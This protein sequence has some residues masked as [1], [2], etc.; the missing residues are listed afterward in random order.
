MPRHDSSDKSDMRSLISIIIIELVPY[1]SNLCMKWLKQIKTLSKKKRESQLLPQRITGPY[2]CWCLSWTQVVHYSVV[3]FLFFSFQQMA[4]QRHWCNF[5]SRG[6]LLDQ[7]TDR[8]RA[9]RLQREKTGWAVDYRKTLPRS[10]KD[11][12]QNPQIKAIQACLWEEFPLFSFPPTISAPWPCSPLRIHSVLLLSRLPFVKYRWW[13]KRHYTTITW[14][15]HHPPRT[16]T[17]STTRRKTKWTIKD[18]IS[19][20]FFD[21]P[22]FSE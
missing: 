8:K 21:M 16:K 2:D 19:R 1:S 20:G 5:H 12:V 6:E 7:L 18:T 10:V 17:T 3:F 22:A 15:Q 4:K 13:L 11:Q 9:V 14:N